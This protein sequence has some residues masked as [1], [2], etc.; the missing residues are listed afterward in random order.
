MNG[1]TSDCPEGV[2]I[3]DLK[4]LQLS[5]DEIT[6]MMKTCIWVCNLVVETIQNKKGIDKD[7]YIR[8]QDTIRTHAF[9]EFNVMNVLSALCKETYGKE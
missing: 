9:P 3:I 1:K 7:D 5:N 2:V 4:K 6:K 8:I